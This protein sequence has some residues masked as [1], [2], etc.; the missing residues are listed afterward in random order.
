MSD[1]AL[2]NRYFGTEKTSKILMK[3]APPV[4][5]A[6]LIQALYNIVDSFFVGRFSGDGLTALSVIYPIQLLICAIAVGTGVG[7]NTVMARYYALDRKQKAI[8]VAGTGFLLAIVS[9]FIFSILSLLFL[10]TYIEMSAS[11]TSVHKFAGIYG[12][13]V[14]IFSLGIFL[15][16]IWTKVLQSQGDM[17]TPMIA[18]V[19]GAVVNVI[20]DPILIFGVW[21]IE[22]MGVA[23]AAIA[24]VIGQVAAA[25]ITGIKGFYRPRGI[26]RLLPYVGAIYKAGIPNIVMQALWTVYIAGLNVILSSFSDAAVTVLGIYYKFQS[27]FLIPLNAL[28]ICILPVVSFNYAIEKWD[29]CKK[30]LKDTCLFSVIFMILGAFIFIVLPEEAIGIF[31]SDKEV[32]SL[33]NIAFKIIGTSFVPI[34]FTLIFPIFFTALGKTKES[35]FIPV[36]REVVLF[37]PVAWIFSFVGVSYVWLTFP[38]T[39][40]VTCVFCFVFY[41]KIFKDKTKEKI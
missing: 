34:T 14:C 21:K 38:I 25:I 17:K 15:E 9:W 23:G 29:R 36:L 5:F 13:I 40:V 30:I 2:D 37:V 35:I 32:L 41:V 1:K 7:V 27:F 39:E 22:P 31:S 33:G 20:L 8:D 19:V 26:K 28:G 24:T 16:S 18:Q 6:Q 12:E 4:M 11:S 3:L 10:T